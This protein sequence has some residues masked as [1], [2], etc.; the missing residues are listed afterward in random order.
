ML[1]LQPWFE[2]GAEGINL[3]V[4]SWPRRPLVKR[5][6]NLDPERREVSD[7]IQNEVENELVVDVAVL[8]NEY[9]SKT[10]HAAQ[11]DSQLL[12]DDAGPS[13]LLEKV[14]LFSREPQFQPGNEQLTE[15]DD[16]FDRDLK[17]PLAGSLSRS[18]TRLSIRSRSSNGDPLQVPAVIGPEDLERPNRPEGDLVQGV[19]VL[20]VEHVPVLQDALSDVKRKLFEDAN[21]TAGELQVLSPLS[22]SFFTIGRAAPQDEADVDVRCRMGFVPRSAP[23]KKHGEDLRILGGLFYH[24]VDLAHHHFALTP[25]PV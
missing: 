14:V 20:H 9:V 15:I 22:S 21:V 10:L 2:P 23:E 6:E 4:S 16:A 19:L 3:G 5:P 18:A 24:S 12:R 8:V 25:G 13:Q 7:S 11:G 1:K 17:Q